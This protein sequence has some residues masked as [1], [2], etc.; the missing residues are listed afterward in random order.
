MK[1]PVDRSILT[2][3][4]ASPA[5]VGLG[6]L[7]AGLVLPGGALAHTGHSEVGSFAHGLAHP[8]GGV[9]HLVAMVAVGLLGA[10]IGGAA[11]WLVPGTFLVVLA[12]SAAA[13]MKGLAFPLVEVGILTSVVVLAFVAGLRLRLPAGVAMVMVGLF[14]VFHGIA[15]GAEIPAG[16]SGL[17]HGAGF[18]LASAGLHTVGI[19]LGAL[20]DLTFGRPRLT[21]PQT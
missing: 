21:R 19:G 6:A 3:I 11:R 15:H 12:A 9:D 14:A 5:R 4:A 10:A 13:A 20:L 7:A 1:T 17:A 8:L 16:A 2:G 18:L